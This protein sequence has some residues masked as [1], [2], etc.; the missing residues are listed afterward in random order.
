M[1]LG[2]NSPVSYGNWT[3]EVKV[4]KLSNDIG[5][6]FAE[7]N[8]PVPNA[9]T[10]PYSFDLTGATYLQVVKQYVSQGGNTSSQMT[11]IAN[12]NGWI[13]NLNTSASL[14]GF[15]CYLVRF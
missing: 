3:S 7:C 14:V 11:Y 4:V 8:S 10:V 1:R 5:L 2:I 15:I 6:V 9:T 12:G 13:T